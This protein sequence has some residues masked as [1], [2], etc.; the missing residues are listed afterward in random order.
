MNVSKLFRLNQVVRS[1]MKISDVNIVF[2]TPNKGLIGFASLILDDAFY[3]RGIAI[4]ERLDGTGYRLTFPT[5]KTKD[6]VFNICHPINIQLSKAIENAIF[7]KIKDV[8]NK[9]CNDVGYNSH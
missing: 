2:I 3:V 7:Q 5:R 8:K 1:P 9:G 6:Q 4:H